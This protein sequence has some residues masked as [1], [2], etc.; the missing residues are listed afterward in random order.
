MTASTGLPSSA[1]IRA[2]FAA[3]EAAPLLGSTLSADTAAERCRCGRGLVVRAP[4]ASEAESVPSS[5]N[6]RKDEDRPPATTGIEPVFTCLYTA[7][8]SC[9]LWRHA[10][11]K[12]ARM[13]SLSWTLGLA[14]LLRAL[15]C[16]QAELG[17][18]CD[19]LTSA[20]RVEFAQHSG[21]MVMDGLFGH[22]EVLR[23]LGVAQSVA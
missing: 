4:G 15:G 12:Y 14:Q 8:G 3:Q 5:G 10:S 9:Y 18:R 23:D 13:G 16:G 1:P 21:D 17:R 20:A 6:C 7:H 19:G 11:L 22:H 2:G